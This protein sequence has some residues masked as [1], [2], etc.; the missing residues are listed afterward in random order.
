MR[1]LMVTPME[2]GSVRV[3]D[4][5]PPE[6]GE[7]ELLVDGVSLGV[8]GTDKEIADGEY[9]TA[10]PGHDHLVL[11]H[12]SLGRVRE[13]PPDSGF[14]P[15]DLVVGIVRRPDPVPCGPC[16]HGEFDMCRNGG[17]TERGIKELHG[18]GAQHWT[19]P[20]AYAVRLDPSLEEVGVLMEPASIVAKAWEHIERIGRRAW[21]EPRT[22]LVTG[23]GPI[24][25]L[26]A[27]LG[28]RRGLDVHVLDRVASGPKPDLVESLGATY[29]TGSVP[30]IAARVPLDVIIE[31]T[32]ADTL[33]LDTAR[34]NA[35]DGIVC[36]VGLSASRARV[37]V[38]PGYLSRRL[39][40]ENDVLFGS[41][42]ANRRH[43]E[44]A[45]R[46]LS[47]SDQEWLRGLITRRIPLD[48]A[49]G[50]FAEPGGDQV[51]VVIDL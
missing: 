25:L 15:G 4:I 17:F 16:A 33:I 1:A 32:G 6:P 38:S 30:E 43:Y 28:V 8:C 11:G 46:Y 34:H 40:L 10:P 18:Y 31:T 29:H 37:E 47:A 39:V 20:A 19:V 41:V 51:K 21:F 7:G 13:A 22:V 2:A 14:A 23:A 27:L 5:D 3:G 12:E 49:P 24:G 48:R 36:Y 44:Q 35:A 42:N 9:G 26:A 45:E 50:V